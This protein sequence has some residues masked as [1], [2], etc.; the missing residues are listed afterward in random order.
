M[1]YFDVREPDGMV[2]SMVKKEL[3]KFIEE[4]LSSISDSITIKKVSMPWSRIFKNA[5]FEWYFGHRG[6]A[7]TCKIRITPIY[8]ENR[9]N[10][11][12]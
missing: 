3:Q 11:C 8:G 5:S 2:A 10:C 6:N 9:T 1:N 4:S 12:I 7:E